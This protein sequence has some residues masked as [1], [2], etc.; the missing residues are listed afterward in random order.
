MDQ[1]GGQAPGEHG[2]CPPELKAHLTRVSICRAKALPHIL[3][4]VPANVEPR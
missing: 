2:A 1:G 3:T 4:S